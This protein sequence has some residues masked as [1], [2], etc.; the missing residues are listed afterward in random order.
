MIKLAHERGITTAIVLITNLED[1]N[2]AVSALRAGAVDYV[3]KQSDYLHRLPIVLRNAY[4][5]TQLE[6]QKIALRESESRY[7]NIFENAVEGIFQSSIEGRFLSVNPAMAHILGY[8]SPEEMMQQVT[9]I[10]LQ[11]HMSP[12]SRHKFVE[13]LVSKGAVE[14]FEAQNLRK[15]G[16]I[17]W[18]STNARAVKDESG[19]TIYFEGFLT[20]I[21][22]RKQAEVKLERQLKELSVLHAAVIAGA[23]CST[24]DEIIEQV[25]RI[26]ARI[27]SEVCAHSSRI[28]LGSGCFKKLGGRHSDHHGNYRANRANRQGNPYWR[29]YERA[30]LYRI[31]IRHYV[32]GLRPLLGA[33]PH[34]WSF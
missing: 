29:L 10:G 28:E 26:T 9:D 7:R 27:H 32:R 16:S 34:Y 25:V 19:N 18:T 23:Q 2:T 33:R 5:Q 31:G 11:I 17:I 14:K 4:A 21:T 3:V 1:I 12:E 20:D 22:D 8:E 15:D 6:K 13:D 24:E 30:K